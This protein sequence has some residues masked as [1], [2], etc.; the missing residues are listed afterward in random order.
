MNTTYT[1]IVHEYAVEAADRG[2]SYDAAKSRIGN[3]ESV[4]RS[5]C[6]EA[7]MTEEEISRALAK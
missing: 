3:D 4:F 6:E 2:D 5:Y 1:A 7:E